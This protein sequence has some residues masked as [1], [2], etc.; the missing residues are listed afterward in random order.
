MG[1]NKIDEPVLV[2]A[3]RCDK[4]DAGWHAVSG[5]R[6]SARVG[7]GA[8]SLIKI[9]SCPWTRRVAPGPDLPAASTSAY[10]GAGGTRR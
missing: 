7:G 10:L 8:R 4:I 9:F 5:G 3:E 1:Y 6:N 2:A